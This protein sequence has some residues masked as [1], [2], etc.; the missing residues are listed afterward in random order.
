MTSSS[1]RRGR[2]RPLSIVSESSS[3]STVVNEDDV[4]PI[5]CGSCQNP[6]KLLPPPQFCTQSSPQGWHLTSHQLQKIYITCSNYIAD[7]RSCGAALHNDSPHF[8]L[9]CSGIPCGSK[10]FSD[11]LQKY[12]KREATLSMANNP[13]PSS[14]GETVSQE[15]INKGFNS[16]EFMPNRIRKNRNET[17][18]EIGLVNRD[19]TVMLPS[20]N[21]STSF[22]NRLN[23]SVQRF[24]IDDV[25]EFV[26]PFCDVQGSSQYLQEYFANFRTRKVKFYEID[27]SI[28]FPPIAFNRCGVNGN[29]KNNKSTVE[30]EC[31]QSN[32]FLDYLIQEQEEE[33]GIY[34]ENTELQLDHFTNILRDIHCN[35]SSYGSSASDEKYCVEN[36]PLSRKKNGVE[37][38]HIGILG[39]IAGE[40]ITKSVNPEEK[41]IRQESDSD[42]KKINILNGTYLVGQPVR[43]YCNVDNTYHVGRIIDWRVCDELNYLRSKVSNDLKRNGKYA[44]SCSYDKCLLLDQDINRIQYLVRFRAGAEGRLVVVHEWLYL[45]EHSVMVGLRLVWV[46][47][48]KDGHLLCKKNKSSEY[49]QSNNMYEEERMPRFMPA[50]IFVRSSLEMSS[51]PRFDSLVEKSKGLVPP[52]KVMTLFFGK[53]FRCKKLWL[54]NHDSTSIVEE[55]SFADNLKDGLHRSFEK[56]DVV[57]FQNPTTELES[58]LKELQCDDDNLVLSAA[59][60]S[61]EI[62]EQRRIRR[63]HNLA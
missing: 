24:R 26:C 63:W 53:Q 17:M 37:G 62:E 59:L 4:K 48:N 16:S 34:Y 27:E 31:G 18:C 42:E 7:K 45:E 50:Q 10:L 29:E 21:R 15:I 56:K 20:I 30:K 40:Y 36:K 57:D 58:H 22:V 12:E 41:V 51:L 39:K 2:K 19:K 25:R 8:H 38:R 23:E 54:Y 60:A 14:A 55:D 9:G 1:E 33:L 32:C 11:I 6:L 44:K 35:K 3:T 46:N 13:L 52:I 49:I 43:L 5:L 61:M 28:D 47:L